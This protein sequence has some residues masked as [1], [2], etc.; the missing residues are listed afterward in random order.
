MQENTDKL[1]HLFG[2]EHIEDPID[3]AL[4]KRYVG[5]FLTDLRQLLL[6][7]FGLLLGRQFVSE[8]EYLAGETRTEL[9][10]HG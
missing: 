9:F 10:E 1:H 7:S 5:L 8:W 3:I 2:L 6:S 4:Q